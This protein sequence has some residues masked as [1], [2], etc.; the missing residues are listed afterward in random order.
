MKINFTKKEYRLLVTMIEISDWI[1]H[2]HPD[3]D[4]PGTREYRTLRNKILSYFKEMGMEDCYTKVGDEY[5]ETAEYEED[6]E[7]M[8]FIEEYSQETFWDQLVTQLVDRDYEQKFG[9]DEVE[10]ET[11]IERITDI[12]EMYANEINEH[13][14][15]NLNFDTSNRKKKAH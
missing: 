2:A 5:Y 11:R 1:M 7:Q 4:Q 9:N 14:L 13:G 3:A 12:E 15:L 8:Q 6:S 10:F